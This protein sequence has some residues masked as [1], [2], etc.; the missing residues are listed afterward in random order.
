MGKVD[1]SAMYVP[2][3]KGPLPSTT[4]QQS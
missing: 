3:F 1:Q 4:V 2:I